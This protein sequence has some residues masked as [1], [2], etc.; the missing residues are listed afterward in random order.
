MKDSNGH[1]KEDLP[2]VLLGKGQGRVKTSQHLV[3]DKGTPL[4]NL[5]LTIAQQFG[6]ETTSFN[7]ASTGTLSGLFV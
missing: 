3:F 6:L 4:A 2:L 7:S 5:N 1:I